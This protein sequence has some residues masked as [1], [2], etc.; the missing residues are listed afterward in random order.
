MKTLL[1][2]GLALSTVFLIARDFSSLERQQHQYVRR[3]DG[4]EATPTLQ[5]QQNHNHNPR[6]FSDNTQLNVNRGLNVV[7]AWSGQRMAKWIYVGLER[8]SPPKCD[9]W[10]G[11]QNTTK[12]LKHANDTALLQDNDTL[13]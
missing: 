10:K 5:Q 2:Y 6:R 13:F 11:R 7:N 9:T 12:F 1:Q 3:F 4:D 8:V